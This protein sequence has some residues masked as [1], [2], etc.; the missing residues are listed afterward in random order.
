MKTILCEIDFK[1]N[2]NC[3][4]YHNI[5][6]MILV[7]F[8]KEAWQWVSCGENI[9]DIQDQGWL[10]LKIGTLRSEDSDG[11]ENVTLK[12]NWQSFSAQ[13]DYSNFLTFSNVGDFSWSWIP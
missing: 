4:S 12:V 8:L 1:E 5:L 13:C 6:L 9:P 2:I 11:G 10:N 3:K 7:A